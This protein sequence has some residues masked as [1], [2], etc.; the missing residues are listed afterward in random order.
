MEKIHTP[1]GI[2]IEKGGCI[3]FMR[4][5]CYLADLMLNGIDH[6]RRNIVFQQSI[7]VLV[8]RRNFFGKV[9]LAKMPLHS[10]YHYNYKNQIIKDLKPTIR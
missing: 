10:D 6:G 9:D 7:A 2:G 4:G 8:E 1:I 3:A 5:L